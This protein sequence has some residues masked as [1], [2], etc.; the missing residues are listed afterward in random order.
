VPTR[1]FPMNL[2]TSLR[3]FKQVIWKKGGE[4]ISKGEERIDTD[5]VF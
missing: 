1:V 5:I 2:L 3:H 4:G